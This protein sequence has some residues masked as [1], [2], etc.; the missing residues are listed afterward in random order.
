MTSINKNEP[1]S[2]DKM[3]PTPYINEK[4]KKPF[5]PISN[6]MTFLTP[7]QMNGQKQDPIS[8]ERAKT[9][10]HIKHTNSKMTPYQSI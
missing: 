5:N 1:I 7:Y 9:R 10:P 2:K 8:N 6:K 4:Q 3:I